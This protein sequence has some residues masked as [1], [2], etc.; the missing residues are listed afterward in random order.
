MDS[1]QDGL[2]V[3]E[4]LSTIS[5][6]FRLEEICKLTK[7]QSLKYSVLLDEFIQINSSIKATTQ[8]KGESLEKLSSYLLHISGGVFEVKRNLRNTTNEI[9]I[10]IQTNT[11]GKVL[12]GIGILNKGFETFI[13]ECK[14]Y[15]K[16]IG[17]TYIGKFCSLLLSTETKIGIM[18]S[19]KGITGSGWNSSCGLVRKFYLHKERLEDRFCIID[20]NISDFIKIKQ[21]DNFFQI[22]N[23]K[24]LALQ[25]G[26][27]YTES[28]SKHPAEE[29]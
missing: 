3:C 25:I 22:V 4:L 15:K 8:E 7:E 23:D 24:L 12:T 1:L 18:F 6:T 19:Y 20:F 26:T 28:L 29:R 10:L 11:K 17:V 21:G 14:N 13:S 27:D 5:Q 9:D 2:N 16:K